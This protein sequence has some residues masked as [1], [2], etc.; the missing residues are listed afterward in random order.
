MLFLL[1]GWGESVKNRRGLV[2]ASGAAPA[3]PKAPAFRRVLY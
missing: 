3:Q 2:D 1:L